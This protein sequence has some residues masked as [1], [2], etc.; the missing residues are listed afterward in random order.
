MSVSK[1]NSSRSI[2]EISN[3]IKDFFKWPKLSNA[4][5]AI[6]FRGEFINFEECFGGI[7]NANYITVK[8]TFGKKMV[9]T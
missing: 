9:K 3:F 6:F 8:C 7:T 5:I 2:W 1:W 4:Q